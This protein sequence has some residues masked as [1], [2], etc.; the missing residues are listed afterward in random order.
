MK[1]VIG[2]SSTR[3]L[4]LV[5]WKTVCTYKEFGGLRIVD[6]R[7]KNRAL[8]NKWIWRFRKEQ[9]ALRRSVITT[10]YRGNPNDLIPPYGI[11][12]RFSNMWR[13][14]TRPLSLSN[15]FFPFMSSG[16]GFSLGDG[17]NINFWSDEWIA[18]IMLKSMFSRVF[19]SAMNK[20][21]KVKEYGCWTNK[22]WSWKVD[23]RMR[24]FDWELQQWNDFM[25]ILKDYLVCNNWKDT[26][27]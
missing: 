16:L 5:N 22:H 25:S 13:N 12:R 14:I 21:G 20:V 15:D 10:K 2:S 27:I 23:L 7:L 19:A 17:S 4:H 8:L 18:G 11:T 9:D 26:L 6:L 24:L 1:E 3:K